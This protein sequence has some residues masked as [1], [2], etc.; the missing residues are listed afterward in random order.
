ME[1]S[2]VDNATVTSLAVSLAVLTVAVAHRLPRDRHL[3]R[4]AHSRLGY[5]VDVAQNGPEAVEMAARNDYAVRDE[6]LGRVPQRQ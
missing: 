1:A 4:A 3:H 5:S 2:R 6:L